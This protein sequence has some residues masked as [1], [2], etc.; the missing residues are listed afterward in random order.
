[1]LQ[2]VVAAVVGAAIFAGSYLLT[3]AVRRWALGR[4]VL[5]RPNHR[6][7]HSHP[8]PRGGGISFVVI[9]QAF[10]CF[11]YWRYPEQRPVWL[12]LAGGLP[13]A[14]IGWLDDV[15]RLPSPVR[16]TVHL[17]AA[18]WAVYWLGGLPLLETGRGALR[19]GP[20][21]SPLAV[22][23]I[24]WSVNLYNFMDGI[25]GLAAGQAVVAGAVGGGLLLLSGAL[26]M[27][28]F[29]GVL[30][31][32]VAGFL[33]WNYPRARIFMGDVGS[34][35]LGYLFGTLALASENHGGMPLLV[36]VLLLGPF[37]VDATATLV[38][39]MVRREKWWEP[40]RTH[41]YQLAVQRGFS[42]AQVTGAVLV[43][44]GLMAVLALVAWWRSEVLP[45][46]CTLALSGL[47]GLWGSVLVGRK[48]T[49][50]GMG[51]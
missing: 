31:L 18:A 49:A 47:L 6:S 21:G 23:G 36:W 1:M 19:L 7:S 8:T 39:R 25:D 42:H 41:A 37:V 44:D 16:L 22:V 51:K 4:G 26:P 33:V 9:T 5:D 10:L 20:I 32:A 30:A 11:L 14:A 48:R 12:A 15:R 38:R 40:H 3:A 46:V 29:A 34:G 27:A 24:A 35:Y 43:L 17:A 50:G 13:V 45:I 28:L 2:V